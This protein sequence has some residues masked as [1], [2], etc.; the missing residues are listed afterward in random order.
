MPSISGITIVGQEQLERL[1][2]Q[3]VIGGLAVCRNDT[4]L[5][6]C[7]GERGVPKKATHIVV[8]FGEQDFRGSRLR[9][10]RSFGPR[11][12]LNCP[13]KQPTPVNGG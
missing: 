13:Y 12:H 10:P 1:L 6:A 11:T 7:L 9:L 8:V 2:A 3:P 5:V 4:T